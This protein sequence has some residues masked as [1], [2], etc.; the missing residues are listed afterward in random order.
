MRKSIRMP[1]LIFGI[2]K[3]IKMMMRPFDVVAK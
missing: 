2:D 3:D 1:A